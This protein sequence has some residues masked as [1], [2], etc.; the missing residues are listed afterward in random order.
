M[1]TW[2]LLFKPCK[3]QGTVETVALHLQSLLSLCTTTFSK[4]FQSQ[5][6]PLMVLTHILLNKRK[7]NLGNAI[8]V[9]K[10]CMCHKELA[11]TF[12]FRAINAKMLL[13]RISRRDIVDLT[14]QSCNTEIPR[15]S[16]PF[17]PTLPRQNLP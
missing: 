13:L 8:T 4:N 6:L 15:L 1:Q 14:T 9:L 2:Q 7:E 17:L 12:T 3:Q 5:A 10:H 11:T 16:Q